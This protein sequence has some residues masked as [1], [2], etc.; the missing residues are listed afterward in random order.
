MDCRPFRNS[1]IGNCFLTWLTRSPHQRPSHNL[2]YDKIFAVLCP[3]LLPVVVRFMAGISVKGGTG[4]RSARARSELER[5][6]M[7]GEALTLDADGGQRAYRQGGWTRAPPAPADSRA[8]ADAVCNPKGVAQAQRG[9]VPA[10]NKM[11]TPRTG[12]RH[13]QRRPILAGTVDKSVDSES[14]PR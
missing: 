11:T 14:Y 13:Q 4:C 1:L 7:P 2:S 3:R 6:R 5:E 10:G 12:N 9:G 8:S